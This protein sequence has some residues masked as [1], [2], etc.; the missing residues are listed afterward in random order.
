MTYRKVAGE[1]VTIDK[2]GG[3]DNGTEEKRSTC[4]GR[5]NEVRSSTRITSLGCSVLQSDIFRSCPVWW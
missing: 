4:E 2:D 1:K 5:K 3:G